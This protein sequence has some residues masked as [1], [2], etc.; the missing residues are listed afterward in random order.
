MLIRVS[1]S[2]H[3]LAYYCIIRLRLSWQLDV[4]SSS[5]YYTIL[6]TLDLI[7]LT[8]MFREPEWI[9]IQ[10]RTNVKNMGTLFALH[11]MRNTQF[12]TI[13]KNLRFINNTHYKSKKILVVYSSIIY[14]VTL[15]IVKFTLKVIHVHH[16]LRKMFITLFARTKIFFTCTMFI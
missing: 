10:W 15:S 6:H 8:T 2:S 13:R 4:V 14:D 9:H 16:D 5:H 1:R 3:C 11:Q 12:G 7:I